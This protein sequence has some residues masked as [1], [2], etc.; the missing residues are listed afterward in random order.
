LITLPNTISLTMPTVDAGGVKL[1]YVESGTGPDVVF[2]HGIPTDLRAWSAQVPAFSSK[3]RVTIYSRRHAMPNKN[4]GSFLESTIQGNAADLESL[5]RTTTSPPVHLIGHSYGG[6]IAA[7]L[8]AYHP[9]LVQKLVLIE[10]GISTLLIQNP[11][12]RAQM[13]SLLFRSPSIALSAGRYVRQYYNPMLA[14]YHK[15]DLDTALGL[16]LDGLMNQR[17]ALGRLPKNV[18]TMVKEN[19]ATIGEVEARLPKFALQE[20]ERI[21]APTLLLN[22]AN[23]TR[24]FQAIN[25]KLSNAI[26]NSRLS[27]IPESSH[28]P[29]F[30]NPDSFNQK[31]LEFV[32]RTTLRTHD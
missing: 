14:A 20:A 6:F 19:A 31:V 16:F 1:A 11:E 27:I 10:P 12:S 18:Q 13:L 22:G 9:E 29:H 24:I 8:A 25:K 26:S 30:E 4:Q 5:I 28:F 15:G 23:G 2:V 7:Y 21:K 32:G 17:G 3:Y